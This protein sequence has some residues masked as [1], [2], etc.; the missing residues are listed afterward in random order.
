MK[1]K[2]DGVIKGKCNCC[3]RERNLRKDYRWVT[4][5]RFNMQE[6]NVCEACSL[7]PN[8]TFIKRMEKIKV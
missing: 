6:F 4:S 3:G 1:K 5:R 8:D 2:G 7:L